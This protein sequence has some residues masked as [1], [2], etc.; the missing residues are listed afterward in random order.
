MI[1][2]VM[3]DSSASSPGLLG[4]MPKWWYYDDDLQSAGVK[5]SVI[6]PNL[7]V[8]FAFDCMGI[9]MTDHSIQ[10]Y[11]SLDEVDNYIFNTA[12]RFL[13]DELMDDESDV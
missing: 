7:V 8:L 12:N 5:D 11:S 4:S 6:S 10:Q 1:A 2:V 9:H 3:R 13:Y